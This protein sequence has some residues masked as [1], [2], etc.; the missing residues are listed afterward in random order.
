MT[1]FDPLPDL[2]LLCDL[3]SQVFWMLQLYVERTHESVV[4]GLPSP[5]KLVSEHLSRYILKKDFE[6]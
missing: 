6:C 5:K 2:G 4:N 1:D 3:K